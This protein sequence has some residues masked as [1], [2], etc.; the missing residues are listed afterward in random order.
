MPEPFINKQQNV[1][2]IFHV[3]SE[4]TQNV[5]YKLASWKYWKQTSCITEW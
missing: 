1:S 5:E 3:F 2:L 4:I